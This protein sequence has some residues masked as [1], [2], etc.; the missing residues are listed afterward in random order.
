MFI[1]WYNYQVAKTI[2]VI[3]TYN[4]AENIAALLKDILAINIPNLTALV[5]DDNSPDGTGTI[6]DRLAKENQKIKVLHRFQNRGRGSAGIDGFKLAIA[7]GADYIIEMDADF[8]HHPKYIPDLLKYARDYDIVIGSRYIK[9]GKDADR[10]VMRRIITSFARQ[11]IKILLG[12]KVKD[13]TSGF[14]CFKRKVLEAFDL[15]KMISTGP[16]IV[17]EIL[18]KA[19][20]KG[21]SMHEIP[22]VFEDRKKGETKLNLKTLFKT[23]FMIFLF[24]FKK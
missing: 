24:R 5:V 17:S 9:G 10:G 6:A 2:V 11:Y 7:E 8:S 18:Y 16:S 13:P 15:D 20:L 12:A 19:K 14:R 22:I 21:F 23:L 4:E 3:P 1:F